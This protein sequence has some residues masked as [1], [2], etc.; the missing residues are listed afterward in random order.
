[1]IGCGVG[2]VQL[3]STLAV[4]AGSTVLTDGCGGIQR[5]GIGKGLVEF[6]MFLWLA[7]GELGCFFCVKRGNWVDVEGC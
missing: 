7:C 4:V 2:R 5:D 1:M 6:S 3:V